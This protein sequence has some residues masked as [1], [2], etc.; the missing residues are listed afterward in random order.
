[1]KDPFV[2]NTIHLLKQLNIIVSK[3]KIREIFYNKFKDKHVL[4]LDEFQKTLT[5]FGVNTFIAKVNYEKLKSFYTPFFLELINDQGED[6]FTLITKVDG[7][8]LYVYN[9][10]EKNIIPLNISELFLKKKCMVLLV[11]SFNSIFF[12]FHFTENLKNEK[13]LETT[14]SESMIIKQNL[15]SDSECKDIIRYCEDNLLFERSQVS[16]LDLQEK[17][18][19]GFSHVR[20]SFS[21]NMKNYPK[22]KDLIRKIEKALQIDA[23]CFETIYCIRYLPNQE[24]KIHHD[25]SDGDK[26]LRSIIIYLNHCINGGETFFPEISQKI[27]PKVGL[28]LS[29]PNIDENLNRIPQSLYASLPVTEGVKYELTLYQNIS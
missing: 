21:A 11:D 10:N 29:F 24:F 22:H 1:M 6:C 27:I 17:L 14:F 13:K 5:E 12:D 16:K 26:R 4:L 28:C 20:T 18:W 23:N 7:E 8:I 2:I 19:T 9:Y 25:A 3:S 15:F